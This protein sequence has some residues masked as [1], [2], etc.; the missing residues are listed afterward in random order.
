MTEEATFKP[1]GYPVY[2][3]LLQ[4]QHGEMHRH[5]TSNGKAPARYRNLVMQLRLPN[6]LHNDVV[7][8]FRIL[9]AWSGNQDHLPRGGELRGERP[10]A[11]HFRFQPPGYS[12]VIA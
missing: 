5:D 9:L 1:D 6:P 4:R 2:L 12:T 11:M 7:R 10:R 3:D 8:L